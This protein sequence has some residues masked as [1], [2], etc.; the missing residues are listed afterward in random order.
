MDII[1]ASDIAYAITLMKNNQHVWTQQ[2][3]NASNDEKKDEVIS[4]EGQ[5]IEATIHS[6]EGKE[7]YIWKL[8]VE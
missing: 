3:E 1:T 8:D 4:Q 7:A 5:N 6:R 2:F